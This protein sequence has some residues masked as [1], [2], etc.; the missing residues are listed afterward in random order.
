MWH[1]IRHGGRGWTALNL[2]WTGVFLFAGVVSDQSFLFNRCVSQTESDQ[3]S[4]PVVSTAHTQVARGISSPWYSCGL[5]PFSVLSAVCLC[6]WAALSGQLLSEL[7]VSPLEPLRAFSLC[8][9]FH[10]VSTS[11]WRVTSSGLHLP[12]N[13]C[14]G[15]ECE[16]VTTHCLHVSDLTDVCRSP[17]LPIPSALTAAGLPGTAPI[18]CLCASFSGS[19]MSL[20]ELNRPELNSPSQGAGKRFLLWHGVPFSWYFL[21]FH[22]PFNC[23]YLITLRINELEAGILYV[24]AVLFFLLGSLYMAD[25]SN[26]NSVWNHLTFLSSFFS[27]RLLTQ[28]NFCH[29]PTLSPHHSLSFP[30]RFFWR[31]DGTGATSAAGSPLFTGKAH[32]L[33]L[34]IPTCHLVFLKSIDYLQTSVSY[35]PDPCFVP[36][37]GVRLAWAQWDLT[38]LSWL[39]VLVAQ[40]RWFFSCFMSTTQEVQKNFRWC[41]DLN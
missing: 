18:T 7:G 36:V 23:R 40:L 32:L 39:A 41:R 38:T 22:M 1:R 5:A 24:K 30:G 11:V 35:Q 33:I 37:K 8:Q 4:V 19:A 25:A 13:S 16:E 15:R 27:Y 10:R 2:L 21:T 12:L 17:S 26:N 28:Q 9:W 14:A 34:F 6:R 20:F 3:S 29:P 31:A